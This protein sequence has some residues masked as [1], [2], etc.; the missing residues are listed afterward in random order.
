MKSYQIIIVIVIAAL[1]LIRCTARQNYDLKVT[2]VPALETHVTTINE[3]NAA[4]EVISTRLNKSFGIPSEN[5][6]LDVSA[7]QILLTISK[8]ENSTRASINE[9]ITQYARLEFRETYENSEL[10]GNLAKANDLLKQTNA[11]NALSDILKYRVT[12]E[13][14]PI[15]SCIIGLA[16][17][18]DTAA[19]SKYFQMP[20]IR[21][22]FPADLQ[23]MWSQNP[24]KYDISQP[25]YE[26]HALK[27]ITPGGEARVD[28]SMIV[29]SKTLQGRSA[30]ETKIDLSMN[31]E[32]TARWAKMTRENIGKCI[33]VVV[34]GHVRSYPRVRNEITGG[35]TE[36]TGDFS[37]KEANELVNIIN[38]G[39]LPVKLRITGEQALK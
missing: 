6:K 33:A 39:R 14:K 4:A 23:L 8:A 18:K 27:M 17:E 24:Y 20:E 22:L 25:F 11:G 2:I 1:T 3:M 21:V 31:S 32:G 10:M 16:S 37:A 34:N 5:I 19:I 35:K 15:E 13:G 26:L 36:I 38:S 28:G 7:N 30:T 12:A 29:S 9:V